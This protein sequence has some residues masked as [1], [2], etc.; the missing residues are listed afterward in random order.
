MKNPFMIF[1]VDDDEDDCLLMKEALAELG[2]LGK[3]QSIHDGTKLLPYLHQ[4]NTGEPTHVLRPNLILLDSTMPKQD[5]IQTLR[6]IKSHPKFQD[7]PIAIYTS[8]MD[9]GK[10]EQFLAA[11]AVRWI[12]KASKFEETVEDIKSLLSAYDHTN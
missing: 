1:M 5:G 8:S 7:I 12:T 11:G 4:S 10:K 3:F 2:F 9:E 6:E